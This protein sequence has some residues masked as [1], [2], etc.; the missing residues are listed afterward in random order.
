[1]RPATTAGGATFAVVGERDAEE[2]MAGGRNDGATRA[3]STVRRRTGEHTA[4]VHALLRHL[5]AV[6]FT[7]APEVLGID[8]QGR[9]VLT[10]LDGETVGDRRPWP[11]WAHGEAALV[12]AGEWMRDFHRAS[13]SFTPPPDAHWFGDHDELR[14]GEVVGHHDAAP[15]NAVWRPAPTAS[16][17]EDGHLV[18]FVDWD[19]AGPAEPLRDLAFLALTWVPLTAPDIARGDGFAPGTDRPRRLRLLLDAYGWRG[20]TEEVLRAV[21]ERALQHADGLERAAAEGYGPAVDL[22]AEGVAEDFRRAVT[23]LEADTPWLLG[24]RGEE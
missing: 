21:R 16:G 1:M 6:G 10:H 9:E 3:G 8:E 17:P 7:R 24:A 23:T 15:Y 19:L 14:A 2:R 5:R 11:A 20:S 13:R 22:V 18:G 12:A 4:G